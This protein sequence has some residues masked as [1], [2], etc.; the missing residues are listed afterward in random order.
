M[1]MGRT[2]AENAE[3]AVGYCK[4]GDA[5]TSELFSATVLVFRKRFSPEE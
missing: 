2:P 1:G 4:R 5:A 3:G